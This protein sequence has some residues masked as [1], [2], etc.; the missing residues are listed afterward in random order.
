MELNA[1]HPDQ[2][3]DI[4]MKMKTSTSC[5]LDTINMQ[6]IKL[7]KDQLLPAIT[8][9]INLSITQ[10]CFP[11]AWKVAKVIPLHK[12]KSEVSP[13]NYRPVSLLNSVSKV[14]ERVI[15]MQ[16]VDYFE[17]NGLLHPSHHGF[18]KGHN[19]TTGLIE[20]LDRWTESFD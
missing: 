12:K 14:A 8:H 6:L 9:I 11:D 20:M 7:G 10:Q 13:E 16:L 17:K 18:C 1:V 5:G 2:V 3:K 15:F 4:I 19:T